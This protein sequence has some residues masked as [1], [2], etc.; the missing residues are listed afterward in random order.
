MKQA[1]SALFS[2]FFLPVCLKSCG[3]VKNNS[4]DLWNE[5]HCQVQ[6]KLLTELEP[7]TILGWIIININ[8]GYSFAWQLSQ[9]KNQDTN[10]KKRSQSK[11]KTPMKKK[12]HEPFPFISQIWNYLLQPFTYL[13]MLKWW[14]V[15]GHN[16]RAIIIQE[17]GA[18]GSPY[19]WLHFLFV[20]FPQAFFFLA[21]VRL[22]TSLDHRTMQPHQNGHLPTIEWVGVWNKPT[23]MLHTESVSKQ[24]TPKTVLQLALCIE[25]LSMPLYP[26]FDTSHISCKQGS[27]LVKSHTGF[28]S[29]SYLKLKHSWFLTQILS[30]TYNSYKSW[31][32]L[33]WIYG[34]YMEAVDNFVHLSSRVSDSRSP[35]ITEESLGSSQL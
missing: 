18:E 9:S 13:K 22:V 3:A 10:E 17:K 30:R 23:D 2:I 31:R 25:D 28:I 12:K 11:I 14:W 34:F 24:Q 27:K 35:V 7:V 6:Q 5:L 16:D 32:K 29:Y 21:T 26:N 19:N 4:K 33:Q 1:T 8:L 15:S 20:M